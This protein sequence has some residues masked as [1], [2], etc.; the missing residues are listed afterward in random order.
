VIGNKIWGSRIVEF[1]KRKLSGNWR[2]I[3]ISDCERG[4][5]NWKKMERK[6][7]RLKSEEKICEKNRKKEKMRE[8]AA[9]VWN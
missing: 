8:H 7:N 1:I 3:E 9:T 2:G 5:R 4:R 6:W